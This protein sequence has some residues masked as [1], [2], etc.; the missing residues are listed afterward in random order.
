[1]GSSAIELLF[2]G[3]G[4][5]KPRR[6]SPASPDHSSSN[7]RSRIDTVTLRLATDG[8]ILLRSGAGWD[9]RGRSMP[10]RGIDGHTGDIGEI[11]ADGFLRITDHEDLMKT[12]QVP[13][14]HEN[15][16]KTDSTSA[17]P[18]H[19][20][21]SEAVVRWYARPDEIERF[22]A[23]EGIVPSAATGIVIQ[24]AADRREV[25]RQQAPR[26]QASVLHPGS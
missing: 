3:Y 20:G 4:L 19:R 26:V 5:T 18:S 2:R 22:A 10:S 6:S 12:L 16:L 24:V 23:T 15:L 1:M 13:R 17:R 7:R 21:Q 8:E 25:R 11:D 9:Y 14:Q